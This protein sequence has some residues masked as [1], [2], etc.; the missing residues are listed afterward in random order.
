MLCH[1]AYLVKSIFFKFFCASEGGRLRRVFSK[2]IGFFCQVDVEY[3]FVILA[4]YIVFSAIHIFYFHFLYFLANPK[5]F[6]FL[7][8][9]LEPFDLDRAYVAFVQVLFSVRDPSVH[10]HFR[11]SHF[12][13]RANSKLLI[14]SGV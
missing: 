5:T 7:L 6:L 13:R 8:F 3:F 4:L 10:S 9:R 2:K 12:S 14:I 1:T 11:F